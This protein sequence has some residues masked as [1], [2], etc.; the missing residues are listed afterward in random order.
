MQREVPAQ[1]SSTP[2]LP[3]GIR[4]QLLEA[5]SYPAISSG[6]MAAVPCSTYT[7]L[8]GDVLSLA[9]L[10]ALDGAAQQAE[11]GGFRRVL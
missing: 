8:V 5:N 11:A 3:P 4:V 2:S 9:V 10:P 7:R 1:A 6:T